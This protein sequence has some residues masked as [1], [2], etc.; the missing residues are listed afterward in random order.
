M[1]QPNELAVGFRELLPFER[2][3]MMP[4]RIDVHPVGSVAH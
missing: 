1:R 4:E 2:D 3:R